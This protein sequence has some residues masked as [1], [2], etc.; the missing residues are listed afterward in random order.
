M[1][2]TGGDNPHDANAAA[3]F[4][5]VPSGI[6]RHGRHMIGQNDRGFPYFAPQGKFGEDIVLIEERIQGSGH[7]KL[8]PPVPDGK[9]RY[10]RLIFLV[11]R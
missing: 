7:K 9:G 5:Q 6:H 2:T 3:D 1:A 4:Q 11:K 8:E 10:I